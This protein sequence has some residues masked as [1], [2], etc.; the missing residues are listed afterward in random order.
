MTNQLPEG[1]WIRLRPR[2]A[3]AK[4]TGL[5]GALILGAFGVPKNIGCERRN[6]PGWACRHSMVDSPERIPQADNGASGDGQSIVVE[7]KRLAVT[8]R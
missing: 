4:G 3:R 8:K 2:R 5:S 7:F 1:V 6:L